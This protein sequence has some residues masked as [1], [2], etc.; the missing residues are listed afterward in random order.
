MKKDR[1][2]SEWFSVR[3]LRMI[4]FEQKWRS[5]IIA[6]LFAFAVTLFA[7]SNRRFESWFV[8]SVMIIGGL[9][10]YIGIRIGQ[11]ISK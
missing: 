7:I 11:I 8:I 1:K 10:V 5:V 6:S 2:I 9:G 4:N 3:G